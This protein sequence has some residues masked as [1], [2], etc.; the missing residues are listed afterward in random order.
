MEKL[1]DIEGKISLQAIKA[2]KFTFFYLLRKNL[3]E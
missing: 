2:N 1:W 3:G